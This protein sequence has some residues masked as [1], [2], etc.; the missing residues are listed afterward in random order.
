MEAG[1]PGPH[2][3]RH[4]RLPRGSAALPGRSGLA[5]PAPRRAAPRPRH[6]PRAGRQAGG[7]AG[8]Y[9]LSG[10]CR[11]ATSPSRA[12]ASAAWAAARRGLPGASSQSP[13]RGAGG[14]G[15]WGAIRAA[16]AAVSPPLS[17]RPAT[18][19]LPSLGEPRAPQQPPP[20]QRSRRRSPPPRCPVGIAAR[21]GGAY[22]PGGSGTRGHASPGKPR[23]SPL[24]HAPAGSGP[25]A[26]AAAA[27]PVAGPPPGVGSF[28]RPR[29]LGGASAESPGRRPT[30]E[31][32]GSESPA[33]RPVPS[34]FAF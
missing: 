29:A 28:A 4:R 19:A 6:S 7:Q 3:P 9:S 12:V 21:G 11:A 2:A 1:E 5:L 15:D 20:R 33:A 22:T 27:A 31:G 16:A 34:C 23:P 18:P 13:A 14:D 25:R 10:R 26:P 17:Q 32:H 8:E 30:S 24:S